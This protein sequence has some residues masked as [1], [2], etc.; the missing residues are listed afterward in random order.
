MIMT[1]DSKGRFCRLNEVNET[2]N[3]INKKGEMAMM[4]NNK[5]TRMETL[6]ANGINTNNFFNLNLDIPVGAKITINGIE[7]TI[8]DNDAVIKQ[9]MESG[10]V[11]NPRVDGRWI[12]A[13]TFRMLNGKSWNSKTR[14]YEDGWDAWLRNYYSYM[15]QF[16]MMLDEVHKLAKMERS[17]DKD[18]ERLSKFFTKGVVC[19][20][21]EHYTCQLEK[22][23]NNQK[24]RKCKGKPYVRLDKYGN[25]FYTDLHTKVYRPIHTSLL[26]MKFITNYTDLEKEL[27]EFMSKMVKLP[28]DTPKASVWKTAF[29]GKG[30]YVTLLNIIKFH[31]VKVQNYETKEILNRDESVAYVESLLETYKGE[32]WRFHEL[33]KAT[34]KLNNFDL[35]ESIDNQNK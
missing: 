14:K 3:N 34:I 32:Y 19:G 9:I 8:D 17:N 13:Q 25:V 29:K 21:C 28:Y 27:R 20:T 15:Y 31:N 4:K 26:S 11:F 24:P 6:K 2:T 12:T 5:E 35:K 30:A 18:F 7:Y 10:Y 16:D 33:L 23:I 22:F 1:R